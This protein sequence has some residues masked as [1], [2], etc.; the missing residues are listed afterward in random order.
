MIPF[1]SRDGT[2]SAEWLSM[3][4]AGLP[5]FKWSYPSR[6]IPRTRFFGP[7]DKIYSDLGREF[8]GA[9]EFG[10]ELDSSYI[11]PGSLEMPTQRSITERSGKSFKEIFAKALTHYACSS[12]DE[13][14]E[15]LDITNMTLNRLSN[16]SG[17]SPIQRVLGYTPRIPGSTF[18]GGFNDHA[19]VSRYRLGDAQVQRSNRMRLAASRAYHEADCDQALHAALHAGRRSVQDL[20]RVRSSTSGTR[21]PT[22]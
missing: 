21:L 17:Y 7:P 9:F 2:A 6:I 10:A 16:K 4:C 19:T 18:G 20:R 14:H 5:A 11:E 22:E 1:T 3:W 8:R 13:W 12:S 15:L